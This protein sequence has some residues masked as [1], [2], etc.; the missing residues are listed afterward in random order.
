MHP[1]DFLEEEAR[2][3]SEARRFGEKRASVMGGVGCQGKPRW[4][5]HRCEGWRD[6]PLSLESRA[7]PPPPPKP[8]VFRAFTERLPE[9]ASL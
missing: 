9:D 8:R 5:R 1:E 2:L 6:N 3:G 4:P 7:P